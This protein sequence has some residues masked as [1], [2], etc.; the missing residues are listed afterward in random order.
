MITPAAAGIDVGGEGPESATQTFE[1]L[2][3]SVRELSQAFIQRVLEEEAAELLGR[4]DSERI[5]GVD[6]PKGNRNGYGNPRSLTTILGTFRIQRPRARDLEERSETQAFP[7][8]VRRTKQV[9]ALIPK[10]YLHGLAGA[11]EDDWDRRVTFYRFPENHWKHLR[12]T[13]VTE[14]PYAS[15]RLRT[16]TAKRFNRVENVTALSWELL[17]V[18]EKW[19]R[20]LDPS[21]QLKNAFEVRKFRDGMPVSNH[22]RKGAAGSVHPLID[23]KLN[24]NGPMYSLPPGHG[25]HRICHTPITRVPGFVVS[26]VPVWLWMNPHRG[27]S[28]TRFRVVEDTAPCCTYYLPSEHVTSKAHSSENF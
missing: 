21:H 22:Q 11:L 6:A 9:G 26:R 23:S 12:T 5:E 4:E 27:T 10:L 16:S 2:D 18:A 14:S 15:I 19:F 13:N 24:K 17:L 3:R 7:M 8:F 20:R 25:G 1:V 28:A